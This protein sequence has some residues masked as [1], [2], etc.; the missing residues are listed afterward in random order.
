MIEALTMLRANVQVTV[1][2]KILSDGDVSVWK[3]REGGVGGRGIIAKCSLLCSAV[4]F[5]S[6]HVVLEAVDMPIHTFFSIFS[7]WLPISRQG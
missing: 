7:F 6:R 2:Y 1:L 3:E 4:M 5:E